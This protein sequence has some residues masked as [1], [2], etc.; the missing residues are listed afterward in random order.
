MALKKKVEGEVEHKSLWDEELVHSVTLKKFAEDTANVE[1]ILTFGESG[2]G[3]TRH[4]LEILQHLKNKGVPKDKIM[5]C[6]VFPDRPTGL[7]KLVNMVPKGFM[8]CIHIFAVNNYEETVSSTA[9]AEKRLMEHY[10][11]TGVHGWLV[12]E[13]LESM[14]TY[15]QDYYARKAYGETLADLMAIKR[16]SV[17]EIMASKDK[18]GKETAYMALEGRKDWVTIKFYHNFNWIDRIKKMPFNVL[19]TSEIKK[20]ENED[21]VFFALKWRPAGEK[22]NIHRFDTILYLAHKGDKFTQRCFKWTG[23]NRLYTDIDITDKG[24]YAEHKGV[25]AKFEKAG[26]KS[27][28]IEELEKEAGIP[29]PVKTT[30]PVVSQ[31]PPPV[32]PEAKPP[33][34]EVK[35]PTPPEPAKPTSSTISKE[36]TGE[37]EKP[38]TKEEILD[39]KEIKEEKKESDDD[40]NLEI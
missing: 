28:A 23:M 11:K 27:S 5:M 26:Y 7:T 29:T 22:S 1:K 6:I 2:C 8:E 30:P 9:V 35:P 14:W 17:A 3:K 33:I 13:L 12:I 25:E 32:P 38:V 39:K 21:S 37:K 31:P 20:E 34:P 18:E 24:G 10:K 19:C 16:Q 4:Y 36:G 40:W 15:S